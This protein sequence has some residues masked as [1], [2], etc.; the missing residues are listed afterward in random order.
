MKAK[1]A[2]V[3]AKRASV[4][5]KRAS[6]IFFFSLTIFLVAPSEVLLNRGLFLLIWISFNVHIKGAQVQF[7]DRICPLLQRFI[8]FHMEKS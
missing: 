3:R 4:K 5:A 2:S 1:R 8:F 6:V 7:Q